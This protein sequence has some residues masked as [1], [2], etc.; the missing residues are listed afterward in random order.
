[1]PFGM[2]DQT[3]FD[4]FSNLTGFLQNSDNFPKLKEPQLCTSTDKSIE[5]KLQRA[6]NV[7]PYFMIALR[8]RSCSR[9]AYLTEAFQLV[10][11]QVTHIYQG[12]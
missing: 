2:P 7:L 9:S 8:L 6:E 1:M 3:V 5:F 4:S 11:I 12:G 10:S